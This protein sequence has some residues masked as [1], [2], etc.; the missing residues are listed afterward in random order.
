MSTQVLLMGSTDFTLS[1][2][3]AIE[4]TG[5]KIGAIVH[6]GESFA[7]SYARDKVRNYRSADIVGWCEANCAEA[8]Q[9]SDISALTRATSGDRFALCV[10]A[11][12][13]HM[14]PRAFRNNF[15]RG[16]IG[17][18][19]S[20]LPKLRGGAPLNW[21]ILSGLHETGLT[22]FEVK[23]GVDN[24]PI[25]DQEAIPIGPRTYVG[26]LIEK[27]RLAAASIIERSLPGI[28]SGKA[29][30]REQTGEPSYCLQRTPEDGRIDWRLAAE[31]IDRLIR[32]VSRP[33]PGGLARLD[34]RELAVHRAQ[35]AG[36]IELSGMPGQIANLSEI[37]WPLVVCGK[38]S[39]A[40]TE[41]QFSDGED[42][43]PL[44]RKSSS[45]RFN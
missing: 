11:G 18:H 30:P 35:V 34:G 26:D 8:I 27:S 29:A 24:G 12:W 32:A 17:F 38:S 21:A 14:A 39:I 23:D 28:L 42:A 44:L 20:L 15:K 37:S 19:A 36:D 3:S 6:V 41:A 22:L 43:L 31:D 7:I 1:T 5:A 4:R 13:Y 16:C 9:Y 45:K 33:Y 40:I 10:L 2:A 25:H